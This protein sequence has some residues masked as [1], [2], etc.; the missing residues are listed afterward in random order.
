MILHA[1]RDYRIRCGVRGRATTCDPDP[2]KEE[3]LGKRLLKDFAGIL[4]T[5][6]FLR[7]SMPCF[8]SLS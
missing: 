7:E 6:N 1:L 5:R 3:V 4:E 8:L 2:S